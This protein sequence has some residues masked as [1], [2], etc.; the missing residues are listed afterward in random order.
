MNIIDELRKMPNLCYVFDG[1]DGK[2]HLVM[3]GGGS[4]KIIQNTEDYP[5]W[6][7]VDKLQ[8]DMELLYEKENKTKDDIDR[9][10]ELY[11]KMLKYCT[12]RKEGTYTLSA[13][14]MYI[15]AC[16]DEEKKQIEKQIK[17]YKTFMIL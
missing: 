10:R 16:G 8:M 6:K 1:D 17:M 14:G 15:E 4:A 2:W 12:T 9:F 3:L 13:Q 5:E 11:N 7:I